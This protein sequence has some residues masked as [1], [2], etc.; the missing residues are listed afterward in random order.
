MR[1][2]LDAEDVDRAAVMNPV[3][4]LEMFAPT[5]EEWSSAGIGTYLPVELCI[6]PRCSEL[7]EARRRALLFG[8]H[9][10]S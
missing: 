9:S 7:P 4:R 3:A 1:K 6:R 5:G 2:E 10:V 8:C